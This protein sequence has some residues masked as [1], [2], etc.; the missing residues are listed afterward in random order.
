MDYFHRQDLLLLFHFYSILTPHRA[1]LSDLTQAIPAALIIHYA[2]FMVQTILTSSTLTIALASSVL[3]K[4]SP[5]RAL[6]LAGT[7][8]MA[9]QTFEI[10]PNRPPLISQIEMLVL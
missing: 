2:C 6:I 9:V 10:I 4:P 1:G 3:R 8:L 5:T 7:C